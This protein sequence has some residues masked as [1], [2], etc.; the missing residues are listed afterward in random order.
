MRLLSTLR[1]GLHALAIASVLALA[2]APAAEAKEKSHK[3]AKK[4]VKKS[5][6]KEKNSEP[7]PALRVA[8]TDAERAF[9]HVD[10]KEWD[11]ALK[12]ARSSGGALLPLIQWLVYLEPDSRASFQE[13]SGFMI[14]H[15]DWPQQNKLRLRA[16]QALR[17]SDVSDSK[18]GGW[19][20]SN[21]PISGYGKVKQAELLVRDGESISSDKVQ[22]LIRDGWRNG[23]FEEAEEKRIL[24]VYNDVLRQ[25]DHIGRVDRLL[26]EEKTKVAR[27]IINLLPD[28]DEHVAHLRIA[29]LEG[30][31]DAEFYMSRV[32]RSRLDDPG[33]LYAR[34]V[35]RAKRGDEDGVRELLLDAPDPVPYPDKWWKIRDRQVRE[36]IDEK[37]YDLARK[38]LKNHGQTEG[39]ELAD[40]TWLSGWLS[41]RFLNDPQDAYLQ[42]NRMFESVK[43]PVSKARAAYWAGRAAEKM[44][45]SSAESWYGTA[46]DF[47]TVLYGQLALAK[48]KP[49]AALKLPSDPNVS[50]ADRNRFAAR[51]IVQ[52]M[53]VA[54]EAGAWDTAT[55]LLYHIIDEA[56]TGSEAALAA[57]FAGHMQSPTLGVRAAKRGMQNGFVLLHEGYPVLKLP[58]GLAVDVALAH[59]VIRQESEFDPTAR[60]K[61]GAVG[62]MQL[63]PSSAKEVARKA[64]MPYAPARLSER[65]YNATLGSQYLSRLISSY[66]GSYVMAVAAYNAGP[67][68]VREWAGQFGTPGG[69]VEEAV[70]WIEKIPFSETRNYVLR[71]MEN[72]QVYRAL[73]ADKGEKA[74]LSIAEDL[75]R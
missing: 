74:P 49:G 8:D 41:L 7:K 66:D 58:S 13:I 17:Y 52:S 40:A 37:R 4:S 25:Q 3:S 32:S 26:W 24:T 60:S 28:E 72:L 21:P 54:A 57:D 36:A 35:W 29:L 14:S 63:L 51:G 9:R 70:D 73:L 38:L 39:S 42:F 55:A 20:M 12:V 11:A 10:R 44:G 48:R 43:F 19:F 65:E 56:G 31:S 64:G 22:Y 30:T 69:S 68:R 62:L 45:D 47:P 23:D 15:P 59:A 1:F 75:I 2:A 33:L 67:G 16:E 50:D 53:R 34:L 18:L 6:K 61:A 46:G 71:V 27:R 5:A